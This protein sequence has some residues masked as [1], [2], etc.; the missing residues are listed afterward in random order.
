MPFRIIHRRPV[1]LALGFWFAIQCVLL[2]GLFIT[3]AGCDKHTPIAGGYE[4]IVP[5]NMGP[6]SHPGSSL[7]FHGKEVYHAL[8]GH[9]FLYCRDYAAFVHDGMIVF[10]ITMPDEDKEHYRYEISPQLCVMRGAGPPVMLSERILGHRIQVA[11]DGVVC[12]LIPSAAGVHVEF[13]PGPEP[14]ASKATS[15]H[16]IPWTQIAQWL[17]TP[18]SQAPRIVKPLGTYRLLPPATGAS[19][20]QMKR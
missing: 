9:T 5:P 6:D 20:A 13:G 16:D 17:D 8:D 2:A 1:G 3:G 10:L 15:V 19:A 14:D 12:K 18:E 4:F 7:G 11:D